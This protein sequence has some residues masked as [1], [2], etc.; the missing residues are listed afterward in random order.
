MRYFFRRLSI[1][2]ILSSFVFLIAGAVTSYIEYGTLISPEVYLIG[3]SDLDVSISTVDN[4]GIDE[5]TSSNDT[6]DSVIKPNTTNNNNTFSNGNKNNNSNN[7]SNSG[8]NNTNNGSNTGTDSGTKTEPGTPI[9]DTS[10]PSTTEDKT[11]EEVVV[12]DK[13]DELR[14][15]IE[16][17]YG[18]NI[19][20]GSE[21]DDYKVDSLSTVPIT[22][23]NEINK[24][25]ND[26]KNTISLFPDELFWE[27]K[28][29]GYPLTIILIKSYSNE[30]VTG[31]TESYSNRVNIS[32][33]SKFS[34][35]E[36][37]NHEV[38]H[39]LE[40]FITKFKGVSYS[41]W[42]TLNLSDF[43]YGSARSDLSYNRTYSED[44]Y[45]VNN[46]AQTSPGEDRASTFEYMMFTNKASCL[47]TN[48]PVWKK[49]K[50]MSQLLEKYLASVK[51]EVTE[52]WER[53]L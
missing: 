19:K 20:Y 22:D 4:E 36:T 7:N 16:N 52:Y 14:K 28:N 5:Y 40:N 33:A 45:F 47:N 53:H 18:I 43:T 38:Y 6:N 13:N 2:I 1:F 21:T 15:S 50:Y 9:V 39:Y 11:N 34:F 12:V 25:L 24:I 3:Q 8:G 51:P 32:I 26:M 10:T 48:K 27:L 49:A 35:A 23:T 31:I 29:S 17:T 46:Y 42:N 41:S 44:A 37:F 30:N